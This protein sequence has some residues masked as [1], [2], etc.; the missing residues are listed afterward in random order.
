MRFPFSRS[1]YPKKDQEPPLL[2]YP[3]YVDRHGLRGLADSLSIELPTIR[4]RR[5]A[6]RVSAQTHGIGGERSWEEGSEL[7]GHIHLNILAEQLKRSAAFREIVDVLGSIPQVHDRGILDAAISHME[8]MPPDEPT[9]DLSERL[10]SAYETERAR[11]V[12]L[13]KRQELQQVAAQNQ[14]VI[15]RGT[16]EAAQDDDGRIC[17]RLTYLEPLRS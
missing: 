14:L 8:N 13:A 5:K 12:A 16:F 17:V 2:A 15:L 4:E 11:E 10:R 1:R 7:E 9:D 6:G 3:Y